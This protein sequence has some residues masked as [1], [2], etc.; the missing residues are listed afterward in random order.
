[1]FAGGTSFLL[2]WEK[3]MFQSYKRCH[4]SWTLLK[5]TETESEMILKCN[6]CKVLFNLQS[7]FTSNELNFIAT[8]QSKYS[9]QL[10][11]FLAGKKKNS[12]GRLSHILVGFSDSKFRFPSFAL[13]CILYLPSITLFIWGPIRPSS[14]L[15]YWLYK[16][17]HHLSTWQQKNYMA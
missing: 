3:G 8:T 5:C 1:M 17:I 4:F 10:L 16:Q 11:S 2:L 14:F 7:S 12:P 13:L 6:I 15:M 9:K